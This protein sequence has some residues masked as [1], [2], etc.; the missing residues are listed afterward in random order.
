MELDF[1][2]VY[3]FKSGSIRINSTTY[4]RENVTSTM[5]V[6]ESKQRIAFTDDAN[7]S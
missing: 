2:Y 1:R 3:V 4:A 6:I 7:S 5:N